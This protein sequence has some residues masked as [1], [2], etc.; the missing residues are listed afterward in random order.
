[1]TSVIIRCRNRLEYTCQC[2]NYVRL[3]T[4]AEH[5]IIV[6]DNNSS[7]GTKEWFSWM[8]RNTSWYSNIKVLHME[9]NCGD[10]GGMLVG[11]NYSKGDYIVQLDNDIIIPPNWL[12]L[13][14]YALDKTSYEVI[15]LKRENVAWKLQA[16][17][18]V[19]LENNL[20]VGSVER[21]VACYM[22]TRAT[23]KTFADG[24]SAVSYTH[25]TLP[26]ILLV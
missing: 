15:M 24:I 10:W 14:R 2:L 3:N 4:K 22:A 21:P 17:N 25:L 11:F 16:K 7:D 6:I 19:T 1:M 9:R 18:T 13:M 20:Q 26:T 5:E 23:F 8:A 12:N